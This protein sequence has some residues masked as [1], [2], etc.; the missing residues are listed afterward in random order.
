M[1]SHKCISKLVIIFALDILI[2]DILRNRVID[3]K[4]CHCVIRDAKSDVLA[5]CAVNIYLTGYRD[6]SG[7]SLIHI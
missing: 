1:E 6:T 4:Q 7:L 5:E 2:I 3:I